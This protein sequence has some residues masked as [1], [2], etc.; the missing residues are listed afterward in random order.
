MYHL[1]SVSVNHGE[2]NLFG[3]D[4]LEKAKKDAVKFVRSLGQKEESA[5]AAP[6]APV[7]V[8]SSPPVAPAKPSRQRRVARKPA[9]EKKRKRS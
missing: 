9:G 4:D 8:P 5:E 7:S 1:I 3:N 6:V 2:E